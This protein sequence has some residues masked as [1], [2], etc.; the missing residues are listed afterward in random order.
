[1]RRRVQVLCVDDHVSSSG[2]SFATSA[3]ECE[4]FVSEHRGLRGK[5]MEVR[6]MRGNDR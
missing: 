2:V 4:V 5:D 1:M 3:T 6:V